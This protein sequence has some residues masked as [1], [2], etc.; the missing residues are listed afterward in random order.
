L[1]AQFCLAALVVIFHAQVAGLMV[2]AL[3]FSAILVLCDDILA[4]APC[5]VLGS[6]FLITYSGD[7]AYRSYTGIVWV[8]LLP[9]GCSIYHLFAY[10]RG[11]K[12]VRGRAFWVLL[13]VSVA[14]TLGGL[15]SISAKEYFAGGALY[16]VGALGFGMLLTYWFL[17]WAVQ[18]D[19]GRLPEFV[20]NMMVAVGLLASFMVLWHY[21]EHLPQVLEHGEILAFQWRNNV[22][23]FLMLALPFPFYKALR[24][25]AFLLAALL[26]YLAMLLSGSRGGLLFGTLELAMCVL[27]ALLADRRRRLFYIILAAALICLVIAGL[28][29][30]FGFFWPVVQRVLQGMLQGESEVRMGLYQRAV[31]NFL[32]HPLF[33]TGLGY[34]GNRDIHPSKVFALCWYHCAPLQIIGSMGVVGALAYG[35]NY[36]MR[37]R[38]LLCRRSSFHFTLFLSWVGLEL[39]SLVNPGEFA[40]VPYLLLATMYLVFAEKCA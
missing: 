2:F 8:T 32:A 17:S 18:Q 25:P 21:W 13:W 12:M 27:F 31:Q 33:G 16:H 6:L 4:T 40:P 23:T 11:K 14:V 34:M 10:Q 24:K 30:L 38:V 1:L 15:G 20:S 22:S 35:Y 5:V 9:L 29:L 39:M 28:P 37:V 3:L 7:A 36:V 26:M 19:A